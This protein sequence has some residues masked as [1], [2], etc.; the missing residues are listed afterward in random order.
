MQDW[1]SPGFHV[2][3]RASVR[4]SREGCPLAQHDQHVVELCGTRGLCLSK[5]CVE[6]GVGRSLR[7]FQERSQR[8]RTRRLASKDDSPVLPSCATVEGLW[9]PEQSR[10]RVCVVVVALLVLSGPACEGSRSLVA[11]VRPLLMIAGPPQPPLLGWP[12]EVA[13][14]RWSSGLANSLSTAT[15]LRSSYV[16]GSVNATVDA[17]YA[18]CNGSATMIAQYVE[19][20]LFANGLK[21]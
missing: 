4:H 7:P 12:A 17:G 6:H 13:L 8:C 10:V 18:D 11:S 21:K 19:S 1:S 5:G 20:C 16:A 3:L 14:E 15:L 9:F 2:L